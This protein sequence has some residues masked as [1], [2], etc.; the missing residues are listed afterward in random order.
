MK[1]VFLTDSDCIQFY[2]GNRALKSSIIWTLSRKCSQ[3][4]N[5]RSC[6]CSN[7]KF[8]RFAGRPMLISSFFENLLPI[9]SISP[10][11]G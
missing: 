6:C 10:G 2:F 1:I 11:S 5:R 4:R 9:S 8:C 3:A 7:E